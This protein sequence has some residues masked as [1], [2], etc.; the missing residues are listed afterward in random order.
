MKYFER[1]IQIQ[2]ANAEK[3]GGLLVLKFLIALVYCILAGLKDTLL[4]TAH[5]SSAEVIP[6][7]KGGII[8]PV[9]IVIV[10]FY[11][12]L[13]NH[14]KQSTIFYST[15]F[16]FL[17]L[18]LLYCFFLYPN[19][20]KVSPNIIADRLSMYAGG[21]HLHWIAV[22]RNWIHVL[23]FIIAELWGQV[24]LMV[25]YWNFVNGICTI[26]EGKKYYGIL[27]AAGDIPLIIT[28]KL[29]Q[30]Y[31]KKY[32]KGHFL[33]TVQAL[34]QYIVVLCLVIMLIYWWV[35]RNVKK[36]LIETYHSTSGPTKIKLS[37]RESFYYIISS[38]YTRLTS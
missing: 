2:H 13:D 16:F 18:I 6:L 4:I 9:S 19:E 27:I 10:I 35:N 34:A 12:K 28:A 1:V 17:C 14:L 8:F 24:V 11:T 20:Y 38:K 33:L 25:L 15:I 23:F 22:F 30:I 36:N 5:A 26:D 37:L 29:I 3:I 31:L 32:E 21:R 7:I